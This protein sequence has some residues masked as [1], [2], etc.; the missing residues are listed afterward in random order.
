MEENISEVMVDSREDQG[1]P[2][3]TVHLSGKYHS[4][5]II[6]YLIRNITKYPCSKAQFW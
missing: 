6:K 5:A 4:E 1:N 2:N 3:Q